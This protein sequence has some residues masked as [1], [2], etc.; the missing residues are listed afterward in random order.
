MENLLDPQVPP[1]DVA[2][3]VWRHKIKLAVCFVVVMWLAVV[4]LAL[5][6]REFQSDAKLLVRIGRE[7]V[8]LDPTATTGQFVALADSRE[9]E[10]HAVEE[11]IA[12]RASAEKIVD[13]F[14]PGVI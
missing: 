9:S 8:T 14:G 4:Y 2:G 3:F 5:A 11:L 6:E 1:L 7:S 10:L 12:S 13:E